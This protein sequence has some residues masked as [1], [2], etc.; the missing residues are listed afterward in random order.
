MNG[1]K[2][3]TRTKQAE[4]HQYARFERDQRRRRRDAPNTNQKD[5]GRQR[6]REKRY[7][8]QQTIHRGAGKR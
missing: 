2:H 6:G 1:A 5:R 4:K 3:E 8:P 7:I